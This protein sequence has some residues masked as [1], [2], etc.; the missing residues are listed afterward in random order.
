MIVSFCE[1]LQ[2]VVRCWFS[3]VASVMFVFGFLI[4]LRLE[5][6]PVLLNFTRVLVNSLHALYWFVLSPLTFERSSL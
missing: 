4:G 2:L 3:G 1:L 6:I 5:V